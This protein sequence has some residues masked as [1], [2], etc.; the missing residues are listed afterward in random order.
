METWGISGPTFIGIYAAVLVVTGTVVFA[1]RHRL[2]GS[3]GRAG[4]AG[5]GT[6]DLAPYDVAMLKGGDSLVLAA[7][8]CRLNEIGG[9]ALGE[10]GRSLRSGLSVRRRCSRELGVRGGANHSPTARDVL[11]DR[12]AE[13]VLAPSGNACG[14]WGCWWRRGSAR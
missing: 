1:I 11:D 9:V 8:A 5:L 6:P 12:A 10:R 7:A 4:V 2:S 13:P 14:R 3:S